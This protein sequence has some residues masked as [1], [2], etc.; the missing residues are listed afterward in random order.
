MLQ[1]LILGIPIPERH[2]TIETEYRT[3]SVLTSFA[4]SFEEIFNWYERSFWLEAY[5]DADDASKW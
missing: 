4:K 2:T 5:T 1:S 3:R